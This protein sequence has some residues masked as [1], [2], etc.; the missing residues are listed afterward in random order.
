[1]NEENN[2]RYC[3]QTQTSPLNRYLRKGRREESD[4]EVGVSTATQ[5]S[6][7]LDS[8]LIGFRPIPSRNLIKIFASSYQTP[9]D[10]IVNYITDLYMKL[11]KELHND[12]IL[13]QKLQMALTLFYRILE[14]I[15][16]MEKRNYNDKEMTLILRKE[17]FYKC[18]FACVFEILIFSY[19]SEKTFPWVIRVLDLSA[20]NFYKVIELVIRAEGSLSR[21]QV[22]HLNKIE[23][24]ILE[25]QAWA[26][27]SP[28]WYLYKENGYALKRHL[29]N[30]T[31]SVELFLRKVQN[32]AYAKLKNFSCHLRINEILFDKILSTFRFVLTNHTTIMMD[33]H[34]DQI[35]MCIVYAIAKATGQNISFQRILTIY[36]MQSP[37]NIN[38]Y[39]KVPLTKRSFNQLTSIETSIDEP[40][41]KR[42][43]TGQR[44]PFSF[45]RSDYKDSREERRY[46]KKTA[47]DR[48]NTVDIN[49]N[50]N[51]HNHDNNN[52]YDDGDNDVDGNGC[53]N[54][55]DTDNNNNENWISS[56]RRRF[57][58]FKMVNRS[59]LLHNANKETVERTLTQLS[60]NSTVQIV[61]RQGANKDREYGDIIQFYNS[62]FVCLVKDFVLKI[63]KL[64]KKEMEEKEREDRN[65]KKTRLTGI[66]ST[67]YPRKYGDFRVS[68]HSFKPSAVCIG[69]T[70]PGTK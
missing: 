21:Q 54:D 8:L 60:T 35:I 38:I 12:A 36:K 37:S 34:I 51:N 69:A 48:K 29:S 11:A 31:D 47:T 63:A 28:L 43:K 59:H 53:E 2:Q 49:N 32:L 17:M 68:V 46:V 1:M 39:R 10:L 19:D 30:K 13:G 33:R 42:T 65:E 50:N 45:T 41:E 7:A 9:D 61:Y 23:E 57:S 18:L 58:A 67:N 64:Y 40:L 56:K 5:T 22:M 66:H 52:N 55:D 16:L 27:N 44:F 70:L 6:S 62:V 25:S 4:L 14:K 3:R 20:F 24:S 15:L 26:T